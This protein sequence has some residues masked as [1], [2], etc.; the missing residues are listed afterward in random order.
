METVAV[1]AL[2]CQSGPRE[3][4]D[5]RGF[6]VR[7][8][9][10]VS[11]ACTNVWMPELEIREDD[12]KSTR[13][14]ARCAL[15]LLPALLLGCAGSKPA[16]KTEPAALGDSSLIPRKVIFGNPDRTRP[17]ISP[18]GSRIA[19][20][21]PKDGVLNVWVAPAGEPG[22]SRP[23]TDDRKRG[24]RIYF[25]A[26]TG[27]HIVYLQDKA[28]NENW[29]VFVTDLEQG[30]TRELT[31]FDGVRAQIQAVSHRFPEEILIGLN[32]RDAKV[33]DV[34]RLNLLTG[35]LKLVAENPGFVGF[36]ADDDYRVRFATKMTPDG[37]TE[38]LKR[39]GDAEWESFLK[40]G[41][42][43]AMTTAAAGLDKE[44]KT[45]YLVDSRGRNTAALN[46]VN[47]E[48]GELSLIAE[49]DKAD[50]ADWMLHPTEKTVQAVA[51]NYE[52]KHWKALDAS[53]EPD[54]EALRKVAD[55]DVEVVSRTLDDR[56]WLVAYEVDD[57]P[58]R[59][60]RYERGSGGAQFLFTNR[61]ELE[62]VALVG[63]RPEIMKSRDGK[64]LVNYLSLPA[65]SDPDGD[66]RPDRPLPMVLHVHGGPWWR[67]SW[68]Y[69]PWHQWFAD[70]GYAVLD[71]NF[72]GSTGFGKEFINAGNL[73]WAGKMHD[74]LIDSVQWAVEQKVADPEKVAIFGGSYGGY[75][76]LV[77]LS[78]T[79]E[80]FACGV[81]IVGPSSLLTLLNSIP[82]YWQPMV[83]MFTS[84]VGDHR[85]EEGQRLLYDRSPLNKVE[86]IVR[87]LLI[88]QGANDPRVK[89]HESD[90]IVKAM[91]DKKL[92]VTYVLYPDE[93]HGFARPENRLSFNAVAEAFLAQCL[94]GKFQPIGEDF[95]GSSIEVPAGAEH[96]P[97]LGQA[98]AGKP[99]GDEPAEAKPA[100]A[101]E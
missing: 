7:T 9:A 49:D 38:V 83:D 43:D 13:L 23:V 60:Y 81:D 25:W 96:V 69:N 52:R 101:A 2:R 78:F 33:F 30:E 54:F 46:A 88:G 68:G 71:V 67:V 42:E 77:G 4:G 73:E 1:R 45:L 26:Y 66:G 97:G 87:P 19:W 22:E 64:T 63:M 11:L 47:L 12:M 84:R 50:L 72:R 99:A 91:Q 62:K 53:L 34:H 58:V 56:V 39:K 76:T 90:Q 18:D 32:K 29:H 94:G 74:D 21:A 93:G 17:R 85:T 5:A 79:P 14:L 95:S 70:R 31:P 15:F 16:E 6:A 10:E 41:M 80:T 82:P 57:G 20:L 44:G 89:Q 61:T 27:K 65:G 40:V 36:T 55:G 51:F 100:E 92:P 75:A 24:V 48:T 8:G 35:E 28:G 98:L 37:G 3:A 59:Y 86:L